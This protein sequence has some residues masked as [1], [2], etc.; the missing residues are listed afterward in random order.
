MDDY[1]KMRPT[2]LVMVDNYPFAFTNTPDV[3]YWNKKAHIDGFY[4]TEVKFVEI[5]LGK[6][7]FW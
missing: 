3:D 1:S 6:V 7:S 2:H 5:K 4:R